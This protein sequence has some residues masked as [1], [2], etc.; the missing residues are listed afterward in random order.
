MANQYTDHTTQA[1]SDAARANG[2]QS[3]GPV[4]PEGKAASSRNNTKHGLY[5]NITTPLASEDHDLFLQ[6]LAEYYAEFD[7]QSP[8]ERDLVDTLVSCQWRLHRICTLDA[9][10]LDHAIGAQSGDVNTNYAAIDPPTR[11]ALAYEKLATTS[12]VLDAYRRFESTVGRQYDRALRAL[13]RLQQRRKKNSS[14]DSNP[15]L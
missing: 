7:P 14:A 5:S 6:K 3:H 2:A 11:A 8:A 10:A 13:E 15:A 12:R 1:Q 9:A 4:T